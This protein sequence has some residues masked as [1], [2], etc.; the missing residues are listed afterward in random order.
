MSN[1]N[2]SL[3]PDARKSVLKNNKNTINTSH[4][5]HTESTFASIKNPYSP[6]KRTKQNKEN[7]P[8]TSAIGS[9]HDSLNSDSIAHNKSL[10][11]E[12]PNQHHLL[13]PKNA[14]FTII[15]NSQLKKPNRIKLF[16]VGSNQAKEKQFLSPIAKFSMNKVKDDSSDK[17][18][19]ETDQHVQ[20]PLNS[21]RR[22]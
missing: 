20:Q 21:Q 12:R 10:D 6:C 5:G 9:S 3:S 17:K 7:G 11:G 16:P 8:Y 19:F 1:L 14:N 2:L 18:E 15:K 4:G 13:P 22:Q